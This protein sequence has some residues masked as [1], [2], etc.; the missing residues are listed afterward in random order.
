MNAV[1]LAIAAGALS[2]I[3]GV[4]ATM[5]VLRADAG[6]ARMQEIAG[7]IQEGA[8]PIFLAST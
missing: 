2:I 4:W 3:Y 7:Y 1:Y 8:M 5:S 6:N